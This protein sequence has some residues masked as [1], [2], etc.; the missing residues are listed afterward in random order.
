M[1]FATVMRDKRVGD[2][3]LRIMARK[4]RCQSSEACRACMITTVVFHDQA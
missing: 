4:I 3:R 1:I 2:Q